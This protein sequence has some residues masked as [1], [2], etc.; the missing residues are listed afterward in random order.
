M[1][2]SSSNSPDLD[3]ISEMDEASELVEYK[4]AMSASTKYLL[5]SALVYSTKEWNLK[6]IGKNFTPDP[7]TG[8]VEFTDII[9]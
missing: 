8:E 5:Y 2:S 9:R 1:A 4:K 6:A 3:Q 7:L